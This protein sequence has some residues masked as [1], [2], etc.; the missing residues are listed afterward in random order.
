MHI[1]GPGQKRGVKVVNRV[2]FP[3]R[4]WV[5]I[6]VYLDYKKE[7][8]GTI[9]VWQDGVPVEFADNYA[10]PGDSLVR[11][12]FGLY[13]SGGVSSGEHYNDEIQIWRL[14]KPWTDFEREPPS[15]WGPY[16]PVGP[17]ATGNRPP[18]GSP[19]KKP[20]EP[21]KPIILADGTEIVIVGGVAVRR[22]RKGTG[23]EAA[24]DE[25]PPAQPG[26]ER[27]PVRKKAPV[28]EVKEPAEPPESREPEVDAETMKLF[29]RAETLFIEGQLEEA[30]GVFRRIVEENP[31]TGLGAKAREYL[32]IME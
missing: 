11:C 29:K 13:A 10:V 28:P 23:G 21:P 3:L 1:P 5:R 7:G 25:T 30:A 27:L 12:H 18:P 6:T 20:K 9:A 22:K 14:D 2:K 4:Q 26:L 16:A 32:E 31:G 15:P 19:E 17:G 24:K 8:T